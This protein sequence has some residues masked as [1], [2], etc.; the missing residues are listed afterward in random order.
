GGGCDGTL[1]VSLFEGF[2]QNVSAL[3]EMFCIRHSADHCTHQHKLLHHLRMV[4]REV[5]RD[6]STVRAAHNRHTFY[7]HMMQD[8][9]ELVRCIISVSG[10]RRSS[11]SSP[12][13]PDGVKVL[14]EVRPH[15]VPRCR[16][17]NAIMHQDDHVRT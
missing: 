9:S 3:Q 2:A 15:I 11:V 10:Y 12:I 1:N 17:Q 6:L 16:M 14:A 4:E 8:G 7:S 5:D 13:V